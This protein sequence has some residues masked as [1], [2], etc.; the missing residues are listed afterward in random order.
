V[1]NKTIIVCEG[2]K[3]ADGLAV[4]FD[5]GCV[6]EEKLQN[7]TLHIGTGYNTQKKNY[8]LHCMKLAT[9]TIKV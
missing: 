5:V 1:F 8:V 4:G 7:S 2:S 9:T 6:G 3:F